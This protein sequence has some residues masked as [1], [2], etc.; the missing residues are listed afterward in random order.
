MKTFKDLQKNDI[1]WGINID[2][3]IEEFKIIQITDHD[4]YSEYE[5]CRN[6]IKYRFMIKRSDY[7]IDAKLIQMK[8]DNTEEIT[9]CLISTDRE[10]LIS[11]YVDKLIESLKF[12]EEVVNA[13]LK[14]IENIKYEIDK[15]TI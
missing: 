3:Q 11:Y 8:N 4:F 14:S 2:K 13:G 15:Y 12:E 7:D 10:I 1:V 5:M 9:Q 6:N